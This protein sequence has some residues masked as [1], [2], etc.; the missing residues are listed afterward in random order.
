[1]ALNYAMFG[2][3]LIANFYTHWNTPRSLVKGVSYTSDA[4]V[5]AYIAAG[6]ANYLSV[7][8]SINTDQYD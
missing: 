6:W 7:Y 5:Y 1:M 3:R 2:S 4:Y 8:L